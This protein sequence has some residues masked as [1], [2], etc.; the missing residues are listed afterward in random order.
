MQRRATCCGHGRLHGGLNGV[1]AHLVEARSPEQCNGDEVVANVGPARASDCMNHVV[2]RAARSDYSVPPC[3]PQPPLE[4]SNLS[5]PRH[6]TAVTGGCQAARGRCHRRQAPSTAHACALQDPVTGSERVRPA[7]VPWM[8][9]RGA[10]IESALCARKRRCRCPWRHEGWRIACAGRPATAPP[11]CLTPASGAVQLPAGPAA[12]ACWPWT[13]CSAGRG[14]CSERRSRAAAARTAL[15]SCSPT[16]CCPLVDMPW[17]RPRGCVLNGRCR[18]TRCGVRCAGPATCKA[19]RGSE[20]CD[21][22]RHADATAACG[23]FVRLDDAGR[24]AARCAALLPAAAS[25]HGA[26]AWLAR[27]APCGCPSALGG[28]H[29]ARCRELQ[30]ASARR[31]HRRPSSEWRG[32]GAAA[33]AVCAAVGGKHG[34]ATSAA[35]PMDSALRDPAERLEA[36]SA[37]KTSP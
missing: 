36:T 7:A 19:P 33:I 17:S 35:S 10:G 23:G 34:S 30:R 12:P 21:H 22:R 3:W 6:A 11:S 25:K 24:A 2:L 18:R 31:R 29:A 27:A 13:A 8:P 20:L 9:G 4:F 14:C 32:L 16:P 1:A 5:I 28:A 15:A 37:W 26:E